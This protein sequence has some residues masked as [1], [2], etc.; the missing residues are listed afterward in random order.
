RALKLQPEWDKG[1]WDAS[2]ILYEKDRF[3]EARD[4]L[5]R[6]VADQPKAGMGWALLGLSEFQTRDYAR[7][8][9]HLRQAMTLGAGSP[10]MARSVFYYAAVLLARFEMYDQ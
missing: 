8:L 9:D 1:L 10:G 5:R 7:S 2:S 4:Y 3:A 6:F